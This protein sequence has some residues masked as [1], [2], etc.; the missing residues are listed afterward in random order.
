MARAKKKEAAKKSMLNCDERKTCDY[1]KIKCS[2]GSCGGAF[3]GLGLIGAF[4][5]FFQNMDGVTFGNV[6]MAILKAVFWPT[7]LIYKIL[8]MFN[9]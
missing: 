6:I 1:K 8:G 5:Y 9:F 2:G 4:I 3:Y 7:L